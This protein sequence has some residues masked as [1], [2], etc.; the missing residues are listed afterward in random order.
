MILSSMIEKE[1][2]AARD[3]KWICAVDAKMENIVGLITC[4]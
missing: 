1:K 4:E 2:E 3:T